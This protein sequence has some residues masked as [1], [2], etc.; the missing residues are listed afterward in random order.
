MEIKVIIVPLN[1]NQ[2]SLILY[3]FLHFFDSWSTSAFFLSFFFFHHMDSCIQI[4]MQINIWKGKDS[5]VTDWNIITQHYWEKIR[6]LKYRSDSCNHKTGPKKINTKNTLYLHSNWE[7]AGEKQT[8]NA[9]R[10]T[11][12]VKVL[13]FRSKLK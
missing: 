2:G 8:V 10:V 5:C 11:L 7:E 6:L 9:R 13:T 1:L 12:K 3:S 4:Q